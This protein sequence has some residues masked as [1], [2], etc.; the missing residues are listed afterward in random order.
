MKPPPTVRVLL[1]L[2]LLVGLLAL[3]SVGRAQRWRDAPGAVPAPVEARSELIAR[4]TPLRTHG[5]RVDWSHKLDLIAF[6]LPWLDAYH[7]VWVMRPDGSGARCLTNKPG[8]L[9]QKHNGCPTWH[10]SGRFIAFA[11]EKEEHPGDSKHSQ[12]G[13]ALACDL[14]VGAFGGDRFWK[15]YETNAGRPV[16]NV[17][18]PHFSHDGSKIMW[19]ERVGPGSWGEHAIRVAEFIIE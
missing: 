15:L 2:A 12:P 19:A 5:G 10:P 11:C 8:L 7:D 18:H 1:A 13:E 14:W 3:A 16:G 4:I 6:D 17:L 9:P